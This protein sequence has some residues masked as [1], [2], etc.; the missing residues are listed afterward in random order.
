[1]ELIEF[2]VDGADGTFEVDA[3]A[4]KSYKT[5]KQLAQAE[6]NPA[7]MFEAIERIYAGRDEEYMERLGD[8][9]RIGE[10]NDAAIKAVA[11]AKKSSASS[12]A[13]KPTAA[14]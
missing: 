12:P 4:L 1:M 9:A 10:L 13:S 3:D 5:M 8:V 7:G 2:T 6:A 11:G 14:R